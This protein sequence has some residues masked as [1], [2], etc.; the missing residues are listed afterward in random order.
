M[1]EQLVHAFLL[2]IIFK[3]EMESGRSYDEALDVVYRPWPK[4]QKLRFP[5]EVEVVH[6]YTMSTEERT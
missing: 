1:D 6:S 4:Q 2:R 3:W 5:S